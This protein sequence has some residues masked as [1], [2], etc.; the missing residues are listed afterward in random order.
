MKSEQSTLSQG[1]AGGV[2]IG[3]ALGALTVFMLNSKTGK[4]VKDNI[5][6]LY[7]DVAEKAQDWSHNMSEKSQEYADMLAGKKKKNSKNIL[8]VGAIAGGIIGVT[9]AVLFTTESGKDAKNALLH[10]FQS[11]TDKTHNI[12]NNIQNTTQDVVENLEDRVSSWV[13]IAQKLVKNLDQKV[14][15]HEIEE[16]ITIDK[17]LDWTILGIR[18]FQSL[19]K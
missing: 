4:K 3:T 8:I 1:V 16:G 7:G 15:H 17:V 5:T 11:L 9:A 10:T 14:P 2:L 18:L 12:A 13:K 19:K 6:D